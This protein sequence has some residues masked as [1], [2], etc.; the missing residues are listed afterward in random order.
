MES[1]KL[2][3]RRFIFLIFFSCCVN[4]LQAQ[5]WYFRSY[6]VKDGMS[7]NGVMSILQDSRGFMWFGTRNGLNRFDGSSFKVFRNNPYD[8]LSIG[9]NS[10]GCLYEDKSGR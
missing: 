7:G 9:S 4:A 8:S 5:P 10:I 2:N 3:I 6:G 1:A